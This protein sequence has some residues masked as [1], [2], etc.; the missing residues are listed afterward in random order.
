MT[1]SSKDS[2]Y[3][4]IKVSEIQAVKPVSRRVIG[5]ERKERKSSAQAL[6]EQREVLKSKGHKIN[7][8]A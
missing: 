6:I 5:D 1:L 7:Y 4:P 3:K 8:L 2:S